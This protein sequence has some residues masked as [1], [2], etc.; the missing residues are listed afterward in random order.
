[1]ADD[2]QSRSCKP[3][4]GGA[5][6]RGASLALLAAAVPDW[7]VIEEHHLRRA[8]KF[9]DFA[10][11]LQFV[12]EVGAVAEKEQHH[13]DIILSW[14]KVEITLFTHSV[15]GL[16]END[17]ILAAKIDHLPRAV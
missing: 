12:N 9:P 3:C 10:S 13:P 2:L 6:L 14:G 17:F 8:F 5:P 7:N 11:A 16:S 15:R 1:M 4:E